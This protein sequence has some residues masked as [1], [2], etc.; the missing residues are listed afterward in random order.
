MKGDVRGMNKA[1]GRG[2]CEGRCSG[3]EEWVRGGVTMLAETLLDLE[4]SAIKQ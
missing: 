4:Y 3:I 1:K 2:M